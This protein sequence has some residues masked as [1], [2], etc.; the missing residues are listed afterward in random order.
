MQRKATVMVKSLEVKLNEECLRS[1]G[2]F[3]W[4]KRRFRGDLIPVYNF[5]VKGRGR[6]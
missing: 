6:H 1:L 4:E 3:S 2:P 5:L